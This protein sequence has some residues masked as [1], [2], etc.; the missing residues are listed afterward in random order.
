MSAAGLGAAVV[1]VAAG[2]VDVVLAVL[3][4]EALCALAS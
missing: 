2:V 1:D 4:F 3:R